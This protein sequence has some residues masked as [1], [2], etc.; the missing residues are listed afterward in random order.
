MTQ[1]IWV[2]HGTLL[3]ASTYLGQLW[4]M[5]HLGQPQG[6]LVSYRTHNLASRFLH[7]LRNTWVRFKVFRAL[8]LGQPQGSWISYGTLVS[9]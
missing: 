9:T 4:N 2:S 1:V 5:K 3:T 7:Q 8:G 6:T